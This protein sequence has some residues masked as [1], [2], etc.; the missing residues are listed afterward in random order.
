MSTRH[1][2]TI[3]F[4]VLALAAC[5][6]SAWTPAVAQDLGDFE[7]ARMLRVLDLQRGPETSPIVGAA[8]RSLGTA[9]GSGTI[10]GTVR[11]LDPEGYGSAWV[12]AWP[13]DSLWVDDYQDGD[14]GD[15]DGEVD[16]GEPRD[17]ATRDEGPRVDDPSDATYTAARAMV[18]MDGSYRLEGLASGD[19]YVSASAKGYGTRYYDDT[20]G[21]AAATV[22]EMPEDG[23]V[24]GIDFNLVRYGAGEGSIEG[25]VT[26]AT[27]GHPIAGAIVHAFAPDSPYRYGAVETDSDGN[28]RIDGLASGRYVVEA[29]HQDYLP[30]FHADATTL[31]DASLV[32]V[33]EPEL[34][35]GIDFGLATGG[36]ISG[37]VRNADG[38]PV[39][40]AFVSATI[41]YWLDREGSIDREDLD[42]DD[43]DHDDGDRED[44]DHED[45][46]DREEWADGGP[47][48][49]LLPAPRGGWAVTDESGAYHM[50]GLPTGDYRV[51]AQASSQWVY[52]FAWY[53]D[54]QTYEGAT[55]V[56]VTLGQETS[57]IDITLDVPATN[58]AIAGRVTDAKGRPLAKAFVTVQAAMY[59]AWSDSLLADGTGPSEGST[60]PGGG[61]DVQPEPLPLARAQVWAYVTTDEDG[62]YLVDEL[63]AGSYLVSA[64]WEGGWEYVQRWYVDAATPE[65]AT[66]VAVEE[67]ERREGIDIAV[68]VRVATSAIVGTVRD[69]DG[70]P[71]VGAFIE[72]GPH[73]AREPTSGLEPARLWAYA[74]T[75]KAGAYRVDRLPAGSYTVHA[76]Y[77]S[78]DRYG[79][80]WYDGAEDPGSATPVVLAEDEVRGDIDLQFVVRPI[81]GIV[82]GTVS[83]AATG[84]PLR[85][86]YV[87]L[88]PVRRAAARSA[89]LWYR[90]P[91]AVTDESGGFRMEWIG[92]GTYTLTVYADGASGTCTGPDGES[93]ADAFEVIGGETTACDVGLRVIGDGE[94]I[95]AGTVTTGFGG[96]LWAEPVPGELGDD[97][98][99]DTVIEERRPWDEGVP[100]VAVVVALPVTSPDAGPTYTAV[101]RPDGGYELRGL[102]TGDYVLMCFGPGHIGTYYGDVYAPDKAKTVRVEGAQRVE[103][104]DFRLEGLY[105][106][107]ADVEE[108]DG[109]DDLAPTSGATGD[110][111]VGGGA[112]VYG[113]VADDAG[114]PVENATVYLLNESEQPVAFAQT[115]S[116]GTFELSGVVPGEYRVYAGK[117]GFA[118][119]YNGNRGDFAAAEPLT[120]GGERT[121]VNLVLPAAV[122]TAVEEEAMAEGAVPRALRLQRNYP[123]PFNPETRISFTVPVSG[124]ATLR[125]YDAVGQQVAVLYDGV[126]VPGRAYDVV[127]QARGLGAGVYFYALE[128]GGRR[129]SRPMA[130]VK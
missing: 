60:T 2:G 11:G 77:H 94:A 27:D 72:I 112:M 73:A 10:T 55:P 119:A 38:G 122:S 89:P 42:R 25:R 107:L 59:W 56:P 85:R 70:Q 32:E 100:E 126:A 40:G 18:E 47:S 102:S 82:A 46:I 128:S 57:G 101:T 26:S 35:G 51:Q 17:D 4:L 8:A 83:D 63:P 84:A 22:V 23:I 65:G 104:I 76:S 79:H 24:E 43:G 48:D 75:D 111:A 118:G 108:R 130:L 29:W 121:V 31:E 114:Q 67:G 92:E 6:L 98:A 80:S 117:L 54:S 93:S 36:S 124:R 28:Y 103:G 62:R 49:V 12:M 123:N 41:P 19:Y 91:W 87:V 120:L 96:S 69:Q 110:G 50:G 53:D 97:S 127:F 78:G 44:G 95:I 81:Y 129:L 125:I 34:T 45:G 33:I 90:A 106:Y 9:G 64:A 16:E 74:Q 109:Q 71:L 61:A 68:P 21:P 20:T 116:D 3:P 7:R 30:E 52:A 37:V 15:G 14:D 113:N 86:A 39:A 99:S 105:R 5:S 1:R 13:A 66:A 115:G 88:S 58:S